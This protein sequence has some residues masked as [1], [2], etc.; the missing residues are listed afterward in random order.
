MKLSK[1]ERIAKID[2]M[3]KENLRKRHRN[4]LTTN[5]EEGGFIMPKTSR[6]KHERRI[7]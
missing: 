2:A 3:V 5:R 4:E 7:H 6:K 1:K